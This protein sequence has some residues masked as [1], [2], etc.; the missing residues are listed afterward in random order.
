MNYAIK[1]SNVSKIYKLYNNKKDRLREALGLSRKKLYKEFYALDDISFELKKG[2]TLG[3]IGKNGSGKSTLLKIIA[4]ILQPSSGSV[5][6][7][8]KVSALIELG[9]G[10]NPEYTGLE[11]IY[12]YGMILGFTREE[13]EKK[14]QDIISFADIG[15]FL[16][17]PIKTY[18]SGMR[19]RLAFSV[20]I[21][22][23][24]EILIVD[25]V[26]SVGDM[27]FKQKCINK[28]REMLDDGLTLF[29]V[30]HSLND[31]K[32]LC[33][34]ALYIN[35]GKQ[36]AFGEANN[37]CNLYQNETS[38]KKDTKKREQLAQ[39]LKEQN[40]QSN[41]FI[42]VNEK[43]KY[44]KDNK[45]AFK[46]AS[47]RSGTYEL[48]YT[49]IEIT[50]SKNKVL[51]TIETFDEI[52]IRCSF[53]S[54]DDLPYGTA[55]GLVC[56]DSKGNDIFV[57]NSDLEDK[58]LPELPKG[59][60]GVW[61]IKIPKILLAPGEYSL[62]IGAKPNPSGDY[63]YD[64]IFNAFVFKVLKPKWRE[65]TIFGMFYCESSMQI[66][67]IINEKDIVFRK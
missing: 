51:N 25:E 10:F 5:K 16:Y 56:R 39:S 11:N 41:E 17:Q 63:Y 40:I 34:K 20:A 38:S 35:E 18:S 53:V 31:I 32:A 19:A 45:N 57:L 12:F 3:V 13:M 2:D 62:S 64:R 42:I 24:P 44:F 21:N 55:L 59:F 61:E 65:K 60:K 30:S 54:H 46:H 33:N 22:T 29:F 52:Y 6:L 4:G 9:A 48:K 47:H 36:V 66:K 26:L 23:E 28:L 49:N 7:N 37:V 67:G 27:F 14:L 1:V 58:Y 15:E 50:D 8:G 43:H